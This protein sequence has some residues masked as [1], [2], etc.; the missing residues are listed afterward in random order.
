MVGSQNPDIK[1]LGEV[2][3]SD[4]GLGILRG[5]GALSEAHASTLSVGR[6]FSEALLRARREGREASNNLRGFDIREGHLVGVAEDILETVQAL[7]GRMK[8]KVQ[9]IEK[10]S[11]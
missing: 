11:E 9:R 2:L 10:A 3:E 5:G 8:E 7:H 4:E 1:H 6:R